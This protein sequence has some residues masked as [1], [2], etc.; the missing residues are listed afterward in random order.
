MGTRPEEQEN[1]GK[2]ECDMGR[3]LYCMQEIED[4]VSICPH[5]QAPVPFEPERPTDLRPGTILKGRYVVG[6]SLGHGGYGITYL[7]Y[8][9]HLE[10]IHV[11]KEY[12]PKNGGRTQEQTITFSSERSLEVARTRERFLQEAKMMTL[13][14]GAPNVV[15][16]TDQFEEN[17]TSYILMDYLDGATLNDWMVVARRTFTWQEAVKITIAALEGLQGLHGKGILHRDIS[18]SNIFLC[19]N[20]DVRIIDF[21]NAEMISDIQEH[22]ESIQTFYKKPYTAPEQIQGKAQGPATDVYAM[23]VVLFKTMTG[24][25]DPN[26]SG[27]PLPPAREVKP[28]LRIPAKLDRILQKA[29][30]QDPAKRIQSAESMRKQLY[31]LVKPKHTGRNILISLLA[32]AILGTA[33][34]LIYDDMT[35][36]SWETP[37]VR[38]T[39]E[40]NVDRKGIEKNVGNKEEVRI[41]GTGKPGETLRMFLTLDD[42]VL[43]YHPG[44]QIDREGNWQ[45]VISTADLTVGEDEVLR[46]RVQ[47]SYMNNDRVM[48][49]QDLYLLVSNRFADLRIRFLEDPKVASASQEILIGGSRQEGAE[50]QILVTGDAGTV[51]EET[52]PGSQETEWQ[53][54]FSTA[55]LPIQ[56]ELTRF[57]IS[58][59]YPSTGRASVETLT[60][61]VQPELKIPTMEYAGE[62]PVRDQGA[63]IQLTGTASKNQALTISVREAGAETA[64]ISMPQQTD[65]EGAWSEKIEVRRLG[66]R[67]G[68][69]R[70]YEISVQYDDQPEIEMESGPLPLQIAIPLNMVPPTI[71]AEMNGQNSG[72]VT[73]DQMT[74]EFRL[75]GTAARE[76]ELQIYLDEKAFSTAKTDANQNWTAGPYTAADLGI[77]EG[78]HVSK[79]IYAAYV[80]DPANRSTG[81]VTVTAQIDETLTVPEIAFADG[82]AETAEYLSGEKIRIRGTAKPGKRMTIR[83]QDESGKF[84]LTSTADADENGAWGLELDLSTLGVNVGEAVAYTLQAYYQ[85]E[86]G[87]VSDRTLRMTVSNPLFAAPALAYADGGTGDRTIGGTET[88]E[89]KVSGAQA[90]QELQL[91]MNDRTIETRTTD[92]AG[93]AE[94]RIEAES[95]AQMNELF[96]RYTTQIAVVSDKLNITV[97]REA[98]PINS[99][100]VIEEEA[101]SF[102]GYGEPGATIRLYDQE[103]MLAESG[104]AEDGSFLLSWEEGRIL[105]SVRLEEEDEYSNRTEKRLEVTEASRQPIQILQPANYETYGPNSR[106][107]E[108]RGSATPGK[109]IHIA[110]GE[111]VKDVESDAESGEWS[112][113]IRMPEI[114]PSGVA[115][116]TVSYGDGRLPA[117]ID[118]MADFETEA[119][120]MLNSLLTQD[121]TEVSVGLERGARARANGGEWTEDTQNRGQVS[122][123]VSGLNRE[124]GLTI[125]TEDRY[126]NTSSAVFEVSMVSSRVEG[127]IREPSTEQSLTGSDTLTLTA[128]VVAG[129]AAELNSRTL[130]VHRAEGFSG[131]SGEEASLV[132]LRLNDSIAGSE[133]EMVAKAVQSDTEEMTQGWKLNPSIFSPEFYELETGSYIL[134]L[135][136]NSNGQRKCLGQIGFQYERS[137]VSVGQ[138]SSQEG[139]G[140]SA[141]IDPVESG[142]N[143]DSV[144]LSG[145]YFHDE[146]MTDLTGITFSFYGDAACT[147]MLVPSVNGQVSLYGR[148]E[149]ISRLSFEIGNAARTNRK[150]ELISYEAGQIFMCRYPTP[151][152]EKDAAERTV[153]VV[154]T[155]EENN[156]LALGPFEIELSS[157]EKKESVKNLKKKLE[158]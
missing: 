131:E 130:E 90:E 143:P 28:D 33:G 7:A 105:T 92:E 128:Y 58:A 111:E 79:R 98:T 43:V 85:E 136:V 108:V 63:V 36:G 80:T 117:S 15:R 121:T 82:E 74:V 14:Q 27:K 81:V 156:E 100:D 132:T 49:D 70:D 39:D 12:F 68:E 124:E 53:Y 153:Y 119:P 147:E 31:E 112:A 75:T 65:A 88:L 13:A 42:D 77:Q 103:E 17:G 48:A 46:Y 10:G 141:A 146:T 104:I 44:I 93:G 157:K 149:D 38:F 56:D 78:D 155:S 22:P 76:Q 94:F 114:S 110:G 154:L 72:R 158:Q 144:W 35:R 61:N 2:D 71:S 47:I 23:A 30:E 150:G 24:R 138:G 4:G 148:M 83:I 57:S 64:L 51:L 134:A 125:E 25:A 135:F 9:Q 127:L 50:I 95:M 152:G 18:C 109:T 84:T 137:I 45:D 40:Q 3:C 126:G 67:D 73:L 115:T 102:T 139:S 8:D 97:D 87:I 34:Y 1:E 59:V 69:T 52:L 62:N 140:W 107:M 142:R 129:E 91:M 21:G 113:V 32:A 16:V 19:N 55:D 106:E 20:G 11:I 123:P 6:R 133:L 118:L 116:L 5:C 37:T 96:V 122:I 89:L 99:G 60:L 120:K 26:L 66:I 54:T 151:K 29:T 145:Y 101:T 86:P 41:Q